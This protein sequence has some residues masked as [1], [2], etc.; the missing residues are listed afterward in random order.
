MEPEILGRAIVHAGYLTVERL[1]VTPWR[2]RGGAALRRRVPTG[3]RRAPVF[4]MSG[5]ELLEEA[6]GGI[7]ENEHAE[8]RRAALGL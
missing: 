1:P 6:C 7:V 8:D 3:P 2:C 5:L 4:K